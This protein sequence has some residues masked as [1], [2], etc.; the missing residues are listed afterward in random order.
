MDSH[1]TGGG[2]ERDGGLTH[3]HTYT[4]HWLKHTP[5]TYWLK[6]THTHTHTPLTDSNTH[7]RTLLTDSNT[8]THTPLTHW[9]KHT[10]THTH[11]THSLTQHTHTDSLTQTHTHS[12]TYQIQHLISKIH[13][14]CVAINYTPLSMAYYIYD[15]TANFL[16]LRACSACRIA[17]NFGE[18][19][20]ET[21]WPILNLARRTHAHC[22]INAPLNIGEVLICRFPPNCQI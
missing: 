22:T 7:T 12:V 9:L 14:T 19:L 13:F 5:L 6:H 11:T 2:G 10:H 21:Y 4:T 17:G 20:T 15:S 1:T 18:S 3:T 16:S 8:H